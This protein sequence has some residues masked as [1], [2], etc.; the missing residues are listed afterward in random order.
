MLI[1]RLDDLTPAVQ[2]GFQIDMVPADR[3]AAFGVLNPVY[4]VQRM[5]GTAHIT[6]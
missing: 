1:A 3:L 4:G 5:V 2:T 6:L